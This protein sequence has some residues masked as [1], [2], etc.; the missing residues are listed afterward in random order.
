IAPTLVRPWL[1]RIAVIA[2][3]MFFAICIAFSVTPV[4]VG[5]AGGRFQRGF[6][7]FY[8]FRLPFDPPQNVRMHE[9]VLIAIFAFA[10]AVALAV[11]ARRA[12]LAVVAFLVGA[13][14]PATL[15]GGGNELGRGVVI[16]A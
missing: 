4:H 2:G 9:V 14:W 1:A 12:A 10:L 3:S 13:G 7:D 8:D 15:L 16:L 5:S 6:L 11:A